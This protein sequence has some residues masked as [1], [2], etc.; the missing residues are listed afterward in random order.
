MIEREKSLW[1]DRPLPRTS[2]RDGDHRSASQRDKARVLHSAAFRRLQSKTQVLGVGLSDFYRTRLTHSLEAAQIGTG[3]ASQLSIKY[4]SIASMLALDAHLIETLCL[5]HDIGHP[6]FGHG[7][8]SALYRKMIGFGGFE[9]NAQTFRIVTKLEPYTEAHGMNLSRRTLLGLIK[10]PGSIE[11]LLYIPT[12]GSDPPK[13]PPKGLYK[14]DNDWFFWVISPFSQQDTELFLTTLSNNKTHAKTCYKSFDCSVME[15]ADDIAYGVH[16]LEDAIAMQL[17][18]ANIFFEEVVVP[19]RK[20]G[21]PLLS[22][23]IEKLAQKLFSKQQFERKNAIGALVNE[24]ITA[25]VIEKNEAFAHPLLSYQA[26]LPSS[27]HEALSL[28]KKFIFVNV[29]LHSNIQRHEFRGQHIIS[30]LFDVLSEEPLRLLPENTRKRWIDANALIEKQRVITD[31]IAGMTDE[32]A[33]RLYA[34][35]FSPATLHRYKD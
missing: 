18:E 32:Y 27:H 13:H 26:K 34:T 22:K 4:S 25:I 12:D 3:I 29:I 7:G 11:Q 24:F 33:S 28:F 15:L 30:G 17:V 5:A 2:S 16:D 14:C 10:Y 20:L 23:D 8:E 35:L 1:S 9:G 19:I 31:Y 6:P 21:I